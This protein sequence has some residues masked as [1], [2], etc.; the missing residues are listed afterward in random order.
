MAEN[1]PEI[2]VE[3]RNYSKLY[4]IFSAV[5]FL[6]TVW[7]VWDEVKVRR[8]WKVHQ[9]RYQELFVLKLDS[10]RRAA[11]EG[12]DSAAAAGLRDQI[13]KG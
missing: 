1:K 13:A 2:P 3:S 8:P 9:A 10:L 12:I 6:G 5:L 4:L 7:S 11:A